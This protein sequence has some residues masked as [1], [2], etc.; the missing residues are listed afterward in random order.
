VQF[1]R[2]KAASP[3]QELEVLGAERPKILVTYIQI[4]LE[5]YFVFL[6]APG[7]LICIPVEQD[8]LLFNACP[9]PRNNPRKQI[10]INITGN[11]R[12]E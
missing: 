4:C 12:G 7:K 2:P 3:S 10:I 8:C 9:R 6:F 1:R 5:I 11:K